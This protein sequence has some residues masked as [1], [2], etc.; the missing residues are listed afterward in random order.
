MTLLYG[1]LWTVPARGV[2]IFFLMLRRPPRSTRTDTLVSLHDALPIWRGWWHCGF[3]FA[4][5]GQTPMEAFFTST[6][7]VALAEM[8]DKTQLLAMLLA[9]RFRK[10]APIILGILA[11]T[12]AN[13]FLAALV[14]HSL[15][16]ALPQTWFR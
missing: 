12:L 6:A 11:A 2:C 13:H 8:G 9:T 10:P 14:G 7:R 5:P 15:A 4:R 3:T 1:L 16:G